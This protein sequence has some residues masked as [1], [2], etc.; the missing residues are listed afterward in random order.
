MIFADDGMA[1]FPVSHVRRSAITLFALYA[2]LGFDFK[3]PKVRGSTDFQW[4]G[5]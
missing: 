3:L 5:Y 4:V 2:A 1:L